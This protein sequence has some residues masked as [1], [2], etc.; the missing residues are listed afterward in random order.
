MWFSHAS[1]ALVVVAVVAVSCSSGDDGAS[2]ELTL[3]EYTAAMSAI[4]HHIPGEATTPE[5][6]PVRAYLLNGELVFATELF[7]TVQGELE[8]WEDLKPPAGIADLHVA[9][10]TAVDDVQGRVGTYLQESALA[11]EDFEFASIGRH[12]ESSRSLDAA[13]QACAELT[14]GLIEQ[15]PDASSKVQAT[16]IDCEV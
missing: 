4:A 8:S 6:A 2:E 9:L 16:L 7:T 3:K 13:H 14:A 11:G 12:E 1:A 15:L 5:Q 10:V